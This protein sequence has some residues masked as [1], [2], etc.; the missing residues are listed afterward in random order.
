MSRSFRQFD[1]RELALLSEVTGLL[2]IDSQ[3][4]RY[5]ARIR[6]DTEAK[7]RADSE[8]ARY[9]RQLKWIAKARRAAKQQTQ[10]KPTPRNRANDQQA[11]SPA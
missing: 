4:A 2:L 7:S 8:C 3:T 1:A 6:A 11:A 9:M 10:P 5:L